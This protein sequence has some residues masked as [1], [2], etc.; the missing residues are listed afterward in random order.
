MIQRGPACRV[1]LHRPAYRTPVA[2]A[3]FLLLACACL[4]G[5]AVVFV[6]DA[7]PAFALQASGSA[8]ALVTGVVSSVQSRVE[9]G[10]G[11][12]LTDVTV[13]DGLPSRGSLP[14]G[15]TMRGGE[16]GDLGMWSEGYAKLEVGDTVVAGVSEQHGQSFSLQAPIVSGG[17]SMEPV[18]G[19]D[20]VVAGVVAGYIY[21]GVHWA[22]ASLPVGYFINPSGLPSGADSA[23]TAAAQTWESDPGSYMNYSYLGATTTEPG[24]Y[25]GVNVIGAGDLG[26]SGVLAVCGYWYDVSSKEIS[27]FD[28]IVNTANYDFSTSTSPSTYDLQSV[29]THELGHT[30]SLLDMY[31]DENADQVMYGYGDPGDT[32]KRTLNWGDI[33]GIN[34]IYPFG[35]EGATKPVWRFRNLETGY[36]LFTADPFEKLIITG[37]LKDTWI[38]EGEAYKINTVTNNTPLWRFRNIRSGFYLYTADPTERDAIVATLGDVWKLEGPVYDVSTSTTGVMVWRFRNRLDGT[39][40]LTSDVSEREDI[41]TKLHDTWLSEGPAFY[42]VP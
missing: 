24:S 20:S 42:L 39:Y 6:A 9:P 38:L 25:D 41:I 28:I 15:F 35:A 32:S 1:V 36:Y 10:T 18:D 40:L 2:P 23:L 13:L 4:V 37:Y 5:L 34:A 7:T 16:V 17:L 31:D 11:Q 14:T 33:A 21:D 12:I 8:P 3:S 29:G 19:L 27:Q 22:D 30:L 26:A